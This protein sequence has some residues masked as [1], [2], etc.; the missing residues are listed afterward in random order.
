MN[1]LL[2]ILTLVVTAVFTALIWQAETAAILP[3]L[4]GLVGFVVY[5]LATDPNRVKGDEK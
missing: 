2:I 4:Y 5:G 1:R 3:L